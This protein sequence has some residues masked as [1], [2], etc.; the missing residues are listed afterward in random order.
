MP[1][2]DGKRRRCGMT[3]ASGQSIEATLMG[4]I[5]GPR[6]RSEARCIGRKRRI[7]K[8]L[9]GR[10]RRNGSRYKTKTTGELTDS[11]IRVNAGK[12][13][14]PQGYMRECGCGFRL[15]Q[16]R[17]RNHEQQEPSQPTDIHP[18]KIPRWVRLPRGAGAGYALVVES[19]HRQRMAAA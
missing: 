1:S 17:Q 7:A 2:T 18:V 13:K 5:G 14:P 9:S 11:A 12:K 8:L 3:L 15:A 10:T 19:C 16:F 4:V 6:W